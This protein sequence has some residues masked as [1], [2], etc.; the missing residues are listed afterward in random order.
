MTATMVHGSRSNRD[1]IDEATQFFYH[2]AKIE[3]WSPA[4]QEAE[5]KSQARQQHQHAP[6]IP[7]AA[8]VSFMVR[9]TFTVL[10]LQEPSDSGLTLIC[11]VLL[12][13][14]RCA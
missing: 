7:N 2:H 11:D 4:K 8:H 5:E 14:D 13:V 3:P 10:R 12:C 1:L 9:N 6:L